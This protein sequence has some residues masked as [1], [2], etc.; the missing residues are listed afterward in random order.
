MEKHLLFDGRVQVYKR[1]NSSKWQCYTFLAGKHRR[2]SSDQ[3]VLAHALSWAEDWYL[4]LRG[5]AR[6]GH[7]KAGRTF[8]EAATMFEREFTVITQGQRSDQYVEKLKAILKNRLIPFFGNMPVADITPGVIQEYR[9]HRAEAHRQQ[10]EAERACA[11]GQHEDE[12][13]PRPLARNTMANE[14]IGVRHVLKTAYRHGWIR[15]LP[16]LSFPY[17]TAGK[18]G[19][20][21]WF[22]LDEYRQLYTATQRRAKEPFRKSSRYPCEQLH[23]FVL[24][25]A[26]TG[27]RPDEARLLQF[28]D[29]KIVHDDR[30]N[31]TI[32]EIEV[33]GKRGVG[34]CKSMPGAVLPFERLLE[35]NK[36]QPADRVFPG[37]HMHRLLNRVLE[38]EQLKFDRDGKPRTA[39]SL[40]HTYICLR[41]ME[42]ADIY[43][44]A[45]NCRTSVEMIENHYAVHLKHTL[46]TTFINVRRK[47][48]ASL[49]DDGDEFGAPARSKPRKKAPSKGKRAAARTGAPRPIR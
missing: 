49:T 18:V 31:E 25:M 22:S 11:E 30:T 38:K 4:D 44:I 1:Q 14:L 42:G 29:V 37:N 32:L 7:L 13:S 21:A 45:K 26:N 41:L 34:H 48:R 3:E 28:R 17:K 24:F 46:D 19:H 5:K 36:P 2:Q 35:R 16:D 10:Q 40:R 20:R 23:D 8:R 43:Y 33:R 15:G 39:Y 12:P 27:L 9:I 47:R 6:S